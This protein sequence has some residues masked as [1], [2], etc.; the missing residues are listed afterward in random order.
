M[1]EKGTR[2]AF[3]ESN[4][5]KGTTSVCVCVCVSHSFSIYAHFFF[6]STMPHRSS[7]SPDNMFVIFSSEINIYVNGE[8]AARAHFVYLFLLDYKPIKCASLTTA[9]PMMS[10]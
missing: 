7:L 4:Q 8:G 5:E 6:F 3:Q 1:G 2:N 10:S 9:G